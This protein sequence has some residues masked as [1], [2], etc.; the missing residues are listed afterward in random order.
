MNIEIIAR[1][2]SGFLLLCKSNSKRYPAPFRPTGV[3]RRI[4]QLEFSFYLPVFKVLQILSIRSKAVLIRIRQPKQLSIGTRIVS[5]HMVIIVFPRNNLHLKDL[6]I[7][8]HIMSDDLLLIPNI[9][10]AARLIIGLFG[11]DLPAIERFARRRGKADFFICRQRV[12]SSADLDRFFLA[13]VF[14]IV[15]NRRSKRHRT[16]CAQQQAQQKQRGNLLHIHQPLRIVIC[17]CIH[18]HYI[19]AMHSIGSFYPKCLFSCPKCFPVI[20]FPA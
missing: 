11:D 4:K 14:V 3:A 16:G 17:M 2:H 12:Y 15:R 19:P 20:C 5:R 13:I 9:H 18:D 10:L 6:L 8:I 7:C 1:V